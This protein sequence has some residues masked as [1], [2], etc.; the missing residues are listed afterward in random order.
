MD[1]SPDVL[2][3]MFEYATGGAGAFVLR[4]TKAL[5]TWAKGEDL[6]LRETPFVRRMMR[7]STGVTNQSEFYDRQEKLRRK[8]AARKGLRGKERVDFVE[9]NKDYFPMVRS[10]KIINKRLNQVNERIKNARAMAP[11]SPEM[12]LQAARIEEEMYEKKNQLYGQFNKLYDKRVG[13]LK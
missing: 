6:E 4:G 5:E 1:V 3:H 10:L 13:R 9:K 7:E 8:D 12:A 2:E 11:R